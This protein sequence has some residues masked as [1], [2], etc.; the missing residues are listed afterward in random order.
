[1]I[2]RDI[3]MMPIKIGDVV[4]IS[5]EDDTLYGT[6]FNW[7]E[8]IVK[9]IKYN[10]S[11]AVGYDNYTIDIRIK[12]YSKQTI[13]HLKL[14]GK[15]VSKVEDEYDDEI[16]KTQSNMVINKTFCVDAFKEIFPE[17]FI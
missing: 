8:G 4:M 7:Y 5:K 9:D 11:R 17:E 13:E 14:Q 2:A 12:K 1:M 15:S 6:N 16:L 3:L 10:E